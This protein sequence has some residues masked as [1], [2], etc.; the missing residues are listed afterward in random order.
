MNS[1]CSG[2][3]GFIPLGQKTSKGMNSWCSGE[4]GFILLEEKS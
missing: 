1:W 2:E 4:G 3:D